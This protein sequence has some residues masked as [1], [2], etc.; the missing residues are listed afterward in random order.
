M[1]DIESPVMTPVKY[2]LF[3]M[4]NIKEEKDDSAFPPWNLDHLVLLHQQTV[5]STKKK[6]GCSQTENPMAGNL[7]CWGMEE[8]P[9]WLWKAP[10]S[11]VY[12]KTTV[13]CCACLYEEG[14]LL[15]AQSFYKTSFQLK[16]GQSWRFIGWV[17]WGWLN[18]QLWSTLNLYIQRM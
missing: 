17:K 14:K 18:S 15:L 12:I 3:N 1:K 5:I 10:A 13:I 9:V 6:K 4:V 11:S 16:A 8:G 2:D 7:G